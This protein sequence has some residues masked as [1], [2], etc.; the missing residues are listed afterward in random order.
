MKAH[1]S[2]GALFS[3]LRMKMVSLINSTQEFVM[4]LHVSSFS[5]PTTR[6]HPSVST[7]TDN[8]LGPS[9][10][11][12]FSARQPKSL[13]LVAP[14]VAELPRSALPNQTFNIT[15]PVRPGNHSR[16]VVG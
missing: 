12:S 8:K 10:S 5:P 2:A 11:R 4:L 9:L 7:I 16:G 14:S 13:K 3:D 15:L 6:P 1:D